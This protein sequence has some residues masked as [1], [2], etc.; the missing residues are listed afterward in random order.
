METLPTFVGIDVSKAHLD[1]ACR[2]GAAWRVANDDDGRAAL[3]ARLAEAVTQPPAATS[4][5]RPAGYEALVAAALAAAGLQVVI[6]PA[7][8]LPLR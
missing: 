1:V 3:A 2:P 4:W 7:Y 8:A 6:N 5:R